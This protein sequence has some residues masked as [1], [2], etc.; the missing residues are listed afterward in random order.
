M[1]TR[2]SE[3]VKSIVFAKKVAVGNNTRVQGGTSNNKKAPAP[4]KCAP[5]VMDAMVSGSDVQNER[6]LWVNED[7]RGSWYQ[8]GIA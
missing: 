6:R 3:R 2:V 8:R 5:M 1:M 4:A 7:Q